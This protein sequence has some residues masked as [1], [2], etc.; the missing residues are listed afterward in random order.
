MIESVM[1]D[2]LVERAESLGWISRKVSWIGRRGAPD[3]LFAKPGRLIFIEL[4]RPGGKTSPNQER[5]ITSLRNAGIEV[6]LIED[7]KSGYALLE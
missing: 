5:E 2:L 6:Y 7:L 3:R 1:E 4:K